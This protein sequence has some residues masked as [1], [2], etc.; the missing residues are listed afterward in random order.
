MEDTQLVV[1]EQVDFEF[2]EILL[3]DVFGIVGLYGLRN[4]VFLAKYFRFFWYL[5]RRKESS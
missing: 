3:P 2:W 1:L 4:D 5:G